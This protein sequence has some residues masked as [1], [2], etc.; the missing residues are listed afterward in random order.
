MLS[1]LVLDLTFDMESGRHTF[2][3]RTTVREE[4]RAEVLGAFLRTLLAGRDDGPVKHKRRYSVRL[5]LDPT[6]DSFQVEHDCGSLDLLAGIVISVLRDL[7]CIKAKD[8][9]CS[10]SSMR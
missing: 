8:S 2:T 7:T 1:D 9:K 5:V 4:A 6:E 10:L 3:D